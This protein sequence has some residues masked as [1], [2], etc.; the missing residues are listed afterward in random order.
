MKNEQ[1]CM[2]VNRTTDEIVFVQG[3]GCKDF[4]PS[5]EGWGRL[6]FNAD[7]TAMVIEIEA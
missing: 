5:A 1:I 3:E 2:W 7:K 4:V 6:V